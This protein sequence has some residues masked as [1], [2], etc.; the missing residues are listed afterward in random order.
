[1]DVDALSNDVEF[2]QEWFRALKYNLAVDIAPEYQVEPSQTVVNL[3]QQSLLMANFAAPE[4]TAAFYQH[5][6]D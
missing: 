3:A 4:E 6:V 2:P 1:M 5:G